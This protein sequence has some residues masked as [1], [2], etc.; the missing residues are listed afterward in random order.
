MTH[1]DFISLLNFVAKKA[2]PHGNDLL[3]ITAMKQDLRD[4]GLDSLDMLVVGMYLCEAWDIDNETS[5][6]MN[7]HTPELL[8]GFLEMH[9]RRK[10]NTYDE[11]VSL[12]K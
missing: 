11:A 10:P 8:L 9:G 6:G 3:K 2:K 7:G 12:I 4:C 1:D 5:K